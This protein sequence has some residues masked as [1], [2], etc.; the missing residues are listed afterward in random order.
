MKKKRTYLLKNAEKL[1]D[2]TLNIK[3]NIHPSIHQRSPSRHWFERGRL[4]K[5]NGE[6]T[7]S[8]VQDIRQYEYQYG[9]GLP[10]Q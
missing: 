8:R 9:C 2:F 3:E 4:W 1:N 10:L 6:I 7:P 5:W